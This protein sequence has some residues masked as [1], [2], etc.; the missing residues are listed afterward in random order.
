M[1]SGSCPLRVWPTTVRGDTLLDNSGGNAGPRRPF[2]RLARAVS[3]GAEGGHGIDGAP[4]ALA[5]HGQDR[6]HVGGERLLESAQGH[7][8]VAPLLRVP[9]R[10]AVRA[11]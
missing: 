1:N 7:E 6:G 3:A 4:R 9:Q 8:R 11:V 2:L 10:L 5:G